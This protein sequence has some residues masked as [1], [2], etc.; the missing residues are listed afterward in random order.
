MAKE[1]QQ[2]PLKAAV[3]P[4]FNLLNFCSNKKV[5]RAKKVCRRFPKLF[6]FFIQINFSG[7]GLKGPK[8]Q[9]GHKCESKF[10]KF[11][12]NFSFHTS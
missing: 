11:T 2:R 7:Q 4:W 1:S 5:K 10:A 9:K 8:D 6:N 3:N 12:D